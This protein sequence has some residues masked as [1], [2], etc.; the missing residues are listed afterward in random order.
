[1]ALSKLLTTGSNISAIVY[2]V[3]V[4]LNPMLIVVCFFVMAASPTQ[5]KIDFIIKSLS[6]DYMLQDEGDVSAYLGIQVTKNA[7]TITLTHPGLIEQVIRDVGL[8]ILSKGKDTL[9][10][11]ILYANTDG[12]ACQESWNYHSILG[13]LN[14]IASQFLPDLTCMLTMIL[15]ACGIKSIHTFVTMFY[16]DQVLLSSFTAV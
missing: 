5:S 6:K 3:L 4:S 13:K 1:L 15:Q 12:P 7:S 14:Y 8:D 9:A 16:L 11:T 10:D 2:S